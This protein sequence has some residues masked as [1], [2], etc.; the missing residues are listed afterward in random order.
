MVDHNLRHFFLM[1]ANEVV[2]QGTEPRKHE[3]LKKCTLPQS[4]PNA[5]DYL[6]ALSLFENDE[7][8]PN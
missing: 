5:N 1:L 6:F 8:V 3:G 4:L 7:N 2:F